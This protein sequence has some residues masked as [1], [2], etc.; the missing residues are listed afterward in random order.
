MHRPLCLLL[1]QLF[2]AST[3]CSML[4]CKTAGWQWQVAPRR[5]CTAVAAAAPPSSDIQLPRLTHPG[6]L[7][8]LLSTL[9][10]TAACSADSPFCCL[11]WQELL[12]ATPVYHMQSGL[13]GSGTLET[14]M[15]GY[16]HS[17]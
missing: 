9:R 11:P 14:L 5:F 7:C 17:W 3:A 6:W 15:A 1:F 12:A 10:D 2:T 13:N 4:Q 16:G 8:R